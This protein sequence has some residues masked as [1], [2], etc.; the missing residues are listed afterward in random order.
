VAW[1]VATVAELHAALAG[2]A[3]GFVPTLGAL[4]EGHL[5]LIRRSAGENP[6]TVVSIFVNPTQFDDP[7]D[8]DR[9]PR[10][11]ERD[12][13]LAARAGA[14]LVWLPPVDEIYPPGFATTVQVGGLGDRWEGAARP[15]HFPAVATVVARLL[16]LVRPARAYFGEKDFQ[17][18]Q[19]VRRLHADLALPGAIVGCSIVRDQ[20]GLALSS[21]NARLSP[22]GRS[23]AAALPRALRRMAELAAAGERDAQRLVAAGRAVLVAVPDLVVDYLAVVDDSTLEPISTIRPASR[24]LGAVRVDGVRLI[25][26]LPLGPPAA[27]GRRDDDGVTDGRG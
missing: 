15:G 2:A 7:A 16:G 19:I 11:Q 26:N 1:T 5:S 13:A 23:A 17:Q 21:R 12:A 18:L 4:H 25:D 20:D 8:L 3:P 14:D 27:P 22:A 6:R 10:D 24:A 9:Y